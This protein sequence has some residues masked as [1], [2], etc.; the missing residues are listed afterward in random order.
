MILKSTDV[1]LI[2]TNFIPLK[3]TVQIR[4]QKRIAGNLQMPAIIKE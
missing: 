3:L 4:S 1:H 2:K